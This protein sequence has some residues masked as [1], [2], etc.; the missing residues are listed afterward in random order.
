MIDP[1]QWFDR[2]GICRCGKPATGI[3]RGPRNESYGTSCERCANTRIN[4]ARKEEE[5][6]KKMSAG[7]QP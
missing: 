5:R 7:A 1:V 2:L 6:A 3:L 4:K